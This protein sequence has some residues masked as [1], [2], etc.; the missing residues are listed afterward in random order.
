MAARDSALGR[1]YKSEGE[2][3]AAAVCSAADE[4]VQARIALATVVRSA[5]ASPEGRALAV[6]EEF[7]HKALDEAMGSLPELARLRADAAD[8]RARQKE[9]AAEMA[10]I[11]GNARNVPPSVAKSETGGGTSGRAP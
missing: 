9:L 1:R 7:A 5:S 4:L 6:R 3:F 2:A 11:H 8:A 10:E